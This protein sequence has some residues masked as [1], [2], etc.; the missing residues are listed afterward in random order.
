MILITGSN[1]FIGRNLTKLFKK[2]GFEAISTTKKDLDLLNGNNVE[3]FLNLYKPL[4]L[5]NCATVGGR[6]FDSVDDYSIFYKNLLM[7]E[8]LLRYNYTFRK[9]IFFSSGAEYNKDYNIYNVKE[10][11]YPNSVPTNFYA[12]S[13]YMATQRFKKYNNIINLRIFNCFGEDEGNDRFITNSIKN[14]INKK[15]INIWAD[16]Y[17]DFFY[18]N[19]LYVVIKFL[20][21]QE[22]NYEYFE[23]NCVYKEKY[24][25]SN[26]VKL[27]NNFKDYSVNV[28]I[29][30]YGYDYCGSGDK[31]N[32]LGIEFIGLKNGMKNCFDYWS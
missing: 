20:L 9:M 19:D 32:K 12:L 4:F 21:F 27:I 3:Y 18:I 22:Y 1:G 7:V 6:R 15:P 13:K 8:N 2:D 31:L 17:F 14:Y 30:G 10:D 29:D 23:Y 28:N 25:L 26:V 11:E 24:K 16:N 5:I